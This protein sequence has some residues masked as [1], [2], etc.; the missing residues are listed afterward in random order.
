MPAS[1]QTKN[2]YD[3]W[4]Y[5]PP[6][7][8]ST[9]ARDEQGYLRV[10]GLLLKKGGSRRGSE[11]GSPK[12]RRR[13]SLRSTLGLLNRRNWNERWFYADLESCTMYYFF[14]EALSREAGVVKFTKRTSVHIPSAV[15]LRGRH[16]PTNEFESANYLE[17]LHT[18]DD[19]GNERLEAFA[20]RAKTT[21]EYDD[22]I[23]TFNHCVRTMGADNK[24]VE[25]P[26]RWSEVRSKP[27]VPRFDLDKKTNNVV[28]EPVPEEA[29]VEEPPTEEEEEEEE[30]ED[31]DL[32]YS[33]EAILAMEFYY[34][35]RHTGDQCGPVNLAGL[36]DAWKAD[37][38]HKFSYVYPNVF[39]DWITIETLPILLRLLSPPRPPPP[40]PKTQ[41]NKNAPR[42]K[43]DDGRPPPPAPT[44]FVL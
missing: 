33:Q 42:P 27:I 26:E 34:Q 19:V 28:S 6:G 12:S 31:S 2:H 37:E 16:A 40:P 36:R 25:E 43:L 23:R 17:L 10:K 21:D 7:L 11:P 35:N 18:A 4:E 38:I 9:V 41:D 13:G 14:D 20:V 30:A 3:N 15:R 1:T 22:W 44:K 39:D 8:F 24:T 5:P 32:Q 29:P